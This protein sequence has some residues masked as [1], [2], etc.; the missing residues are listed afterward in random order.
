MKYGFNSSKIK[1]STIGDM[2]Y[3][4]A[5]ETFMPMPANDLSGQMTDT[6]SV[7]A[8]VWGAMETKAAGSFR[9]LGINLDETEAPTHVFYIRFWKAEFL[10]ARFI[11]FNGNRYKIIKPHDIRGNQQSNYQISFNCV[12]KGAVGKKAS[13]YK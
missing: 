13:T 8:T 5:I 7:I 12:F 2:R 11:S 9:L 3:R 6:I 1:R 10:E 4:L